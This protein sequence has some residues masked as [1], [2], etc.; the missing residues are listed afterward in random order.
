MTM[1]DGSRGEPWT[2]EHPSSAIEIPNTIRFMMSFSFS[3]GGR[4]LDDER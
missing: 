3:T 4:H 2:G 1:W